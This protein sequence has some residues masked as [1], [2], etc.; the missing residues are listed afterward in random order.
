MSKKCDELKILF[1]SINNVWRYGNIG[2][3]QLTGYLREKGFS[4]DIKYFSN[5]ALETEIL[6]SISY[7]YDVF[8]FSVNSSNYSK[9]CNLAK[10]IKNTNNNSVIVFGGGYPTRYYKETLNENSAVDYIIIGDGEEPTESLFKALCEGKKEV[11]HSSI[12]THNDMTDKKDN[13]NKDILYLPAFDYYENDTKARNSRKVHCI[14]IKNNVCT[15]NC[16]FC[17]ERHGEIKYKSIDS[18]INEIKI[19]HTKYGVKKIFFTDDNILDPNNTYAK[20]HLKELCLNIEKL[21]FKIAFQC[22][23]KAISLN[24]TQED[25]YLLRLMKKV[26]FVEVFIGLESGN[27]QDL[28]LYNKHTTVEDNYQIISLLK[29]S[30]LIPIIG[31]ISFNPYTTLQQITENFEFLCNVECTYL[32]NY[33]YSFVVINKYTPLYQKLLNDDLI[34]NKQDKCINIEYKFK[35]KDVEEILFYIKNEMIPKL[36][37]I[38]YQLDWVNYSFEEH[39][40]W[41]D[42]IIDY[43]DVLRKYKEEDLFIIK[44]YLSILFVEHNLEKFRNL[45]NCFWEHFQNRERLLKPIYQYLISLHK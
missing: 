29:E 36:N 44:K 17:N 43:S 26:G 13:L 19:V 37:K 28:N 1:I 5:K 21:D 2:L 32:F 12:A 16:S 42:E 24:D 3:D 39:K 35:N 45:E 10:E 18:I 34:I 7:N 11:S 6:N 41:F 40:I 20:E 15:G 30:E 4:V 14:Q 9:C 33:I 23:I 27:Q 8:G 25:R 22:Y 31:F 38:E